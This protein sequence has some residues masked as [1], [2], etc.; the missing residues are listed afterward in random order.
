MIV[1]IERIIIT[2]EYKYYKQIVT[3]IIIDKLNI[4]LL[5]IYINALI[6]YNNNDNND[7]YINILNY[8][9]KN[10]YKFNNKIEGFK[11]NSEYYIYDTKKKSKYSNKFN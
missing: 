8:L 5:N 2:S 4:N 7:I 1:I 11:Y 9:N 6:E 3:N 10:L